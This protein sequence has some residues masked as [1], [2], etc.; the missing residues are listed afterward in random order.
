MNRDGQEII[1]YYF[2]KASSHSFVYGLPGDVII[3]LYRR[4]LDANPDIC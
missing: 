4:Y 3:Y 2:L 1:K